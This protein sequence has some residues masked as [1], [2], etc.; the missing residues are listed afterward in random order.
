MDLLS[1]TIANIK[2]ISSSLLSEAQDKQDNLTKPRGAFGRL[3]DLSIKIAG[4]QNTLTPKIK[5]KAVLLFG[6]DHLTV[7]EEGIA[8]API[9]VT[10][11]M[12]QNFV[13]S[14][15]AGVNVIADSI[16]A[17]VV[18]TDVGVATEYPVDLPIYKKSIQKGANNI[19]KGP[20]MT[21]E[22]AT[23]SVEV[24][25]EVLLDQ[26][27]RGLDII[28]VGEMGIGNTT[29]SSAIFSFITGQDVDLVTGPGAGIIDQKIMK[30]REVIKKA[31]L[32]N[33]IDPNNG[34]DILAK[35]GGFEIGAMAGAMIG[36]AS[37]QIPVMVDGFIATAAALI[38]IKITP[39]IEPYLISAHHSA[40]TG[41]N[42]V[43]D[44][45]QQKPLLDLGMRLGEG[46]GALLGISLAEVA[47]N[48]FNNMTTFTDAEV[49]KAE[50][51]NTL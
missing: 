2:P 12:M 19:C 40:E 3:E 20:A 6:G 27:K 13:E 41:Y 18:V 14:K 47:V 7:H 9:E 26:K 21:L 45:L 23:R 33:K 8:S 38:A 43:I 36:A 10:A 17:R 25:I 15:G 11:Q 42:K 50:E 22:Q 24:G 51:R 29:P 34:L 49:I 28:A 31:L 4:I 44:F 32:I 30:K 37:V 35:I 1:S 39:S 48:I 5:D 16:G 46:T